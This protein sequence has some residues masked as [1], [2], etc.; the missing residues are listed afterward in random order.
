M[1]RKPSFM[2]NNEML[3]NKVFPKLRKSR[4]L[5]VWFDSLTEEERYIVSGT[6]NRTE[7]AVKFAQLP[8]SEKEKIFDKYDKKFEDIRAE[9]NNAH[10]KKILEIKMALHLKQ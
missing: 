8:I 5:H 9:K 2:E 10:L 3:I 1:I 7:A 4:S 6:K